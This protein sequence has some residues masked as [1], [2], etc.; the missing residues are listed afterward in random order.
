MN[1]LNIEQSYKAMYVFLDNYWE[2]DPSSDLGALLGSIN[3]FL[4]GDDNMP[5]DE[6]F[7][8]DWLDVFKGNNILKENIS[9]DE[10]YSSMI[11]FLEKQKENLNLKF[12]KIISDLRNGYED[13]NSAYWKLWIDCCIDEIGR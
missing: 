10:C 1:N 5:I 9:I 3:P 2:R 12:E 6:S 11:Y 8:V 4:W 13:K 7:V